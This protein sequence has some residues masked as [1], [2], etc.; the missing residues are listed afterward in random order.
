MKYNI[1]IQV[2]SED[3]EEIVGSRETSST[4]IASQVINDI[5][6]WISDYERENYHDCKQCGKEF[7][8]SKLIVAED[9]ESNLYCDKCIENI[10]VNKE[11]LR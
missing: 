11:E 6:K 3:T 9:G 8:I 1:K 5:P 4:E 10:I 2:I 7:H